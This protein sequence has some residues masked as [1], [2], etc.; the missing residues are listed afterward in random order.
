M[1]Y[2]GKQMEKLVYDLGDCQFFYNDLDVS[3]TLPSRLDEYQL[4]IAF[5]LSPSFFPSL[6]R[7]FSFGDSLNVTR[8]V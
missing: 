8:H 2:Y 4:L 6:S 1:R 5:S 3:Y 7:S